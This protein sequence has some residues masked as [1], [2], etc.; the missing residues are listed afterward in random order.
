MRCSNDSLL[1]YHV[2]GAGSS[3]EINKK[4]KKMQLFPVFLWVFVCPV[5]FCLFP[6]ALIE[7]P[8]ETRNVKLVPFFGVLKQTSEALLDDQATPLP[9]APA[10]SLLGSVSPDHHAR[11]LV[12][13]HGS[14][15]WLREDECLV[16]TAPQG[17]GQRCFIEPGVQLAPSQS[18]GPLPLLPFHLSSS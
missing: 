17:P 14:K 9:F 13:V 2:Q 3:T 6:S 12:L 15:A 4:S 11:T 8:L 5:C 7:F 1:A 18:L 10:T 16:K